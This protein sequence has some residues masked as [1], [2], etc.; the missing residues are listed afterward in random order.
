MP[1]KGNTE[2]PISVAIFV[3]PELWFLLAVVVGIAAGFKYG[4]IFGAL[5]FFAALV[6]TWR[7]E[8]HHATF[9]CQTCHRS[10]R[11]RELATTRANAP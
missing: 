8:T 2:I 6:V 7:Y 3:V 10:L 4:L 5:A 9:Q 1:P 11:F